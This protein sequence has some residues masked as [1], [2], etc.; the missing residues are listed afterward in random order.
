MS[1]TTRPTTEI[2][3]RSLREADAAR[4]LEMS[5]AFLRA[6]R[7]GRCDGPIFVRIGHSIRYRPAD[8][9]RFLKSR[10]V[11]VRSGREGEAAER[12]RP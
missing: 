1:R 11:V 8:L 10:R 9:D 2:T 7:M 12:S 4:Y 6:A 3:P 5:P